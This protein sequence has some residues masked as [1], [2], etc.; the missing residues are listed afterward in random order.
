V[1]QVYERN[2]FNFGTS[3]PEVEKVKCKPSHELLAVVFCAYI[4]GLHM[5]TTTKHHSEVKAVS[6]GGKIIKF[7]SLTPILSP[8]ERERRKKEVEKQLFN[9]FAKYAK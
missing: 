5:T 6:F 2:F 4:G 3:C 9:V 8:K 7:E 1:K